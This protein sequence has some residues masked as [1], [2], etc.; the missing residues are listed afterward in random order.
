MSL[1]GGR[2]LGPGLLLDLNYTSG[3]LGSTTLTR[4]S[5]ATYFNSS[6][7]LTSAAT[8]VARFDYNPATLSAVGLLVEP[9]R[10]NLC[11]QSQSATGW[12]STGTL[13]GNQLTSP[14]GTVNANLLTATTNFCDA[15]SSITITATSHTW[16]CYLKKGTASWA[17]ISAYDG[18]HNYSYVNMNTGALGNSASG[19]TATVQDVGNGWLRVSLS[20]TSG[21]TSGYFVVG[22]CNSNGS[23]TST[24]G[25]TLYFYGAQLEA[26]STASTY[27]PTT[28]ASVTRSAD[29]ATITI[30]AGVS[31]IRYTFDN[32]TTQD[33]SVT[34]GSYTIPTSLNRTRIKRIHSL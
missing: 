7:T 27:I 31:T 34:A 1:T 16:S 25:E 6:G 21:G 26:G 17:Y 8:D 15:Y 4:S 20:R 22:L 11:L 5:S 24:A 29:V 32:D 9:S 33:V 12:E 19:N 10:A 23:I 18:G 3:S 28:T 13:S 30:P 2:V 14:D